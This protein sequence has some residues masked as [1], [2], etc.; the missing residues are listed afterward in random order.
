MPLMIEHDQRLASSVELAFHPGK[1]PQFQFPP[2][3]VSDQKLFDWREESPTNATERLAIFYG[4]QGRKLVIEA[5]YVIDD[6][7]TIEKVV[8]NVRAIR[9]HFYEGAVIG[10]ARWV[11]VRFYRISEAG[12]TYRVT[13]C[14]IKHDGPIMGGGNDSYPMVTIVTLEMIFVSKMRDKGSDAKLDVGKLVPTP[15]NHPEWY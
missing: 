7:W 14:D 13:S 8:T 9:A 6:D 4:G 1:T 11:T 2:I 3:C 5:R 10:K 12:G 15:I